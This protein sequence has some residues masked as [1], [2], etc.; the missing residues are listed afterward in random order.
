M[1]TQTINKLLATM[2][3]L[4]SAP[5]AKAGAL[6]ST[7]MVSIRGVLRAMNIDESQISNET[8][9]QLRTQGTEILN[10]EKSKSDYLNNV[11][12]LKLTCGSGSHG[13]DKDPV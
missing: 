9:E 2:I 5:Y 6:S 11:N 8:I 10:Y 13:G 3:I 1:K 4:A 7:E 12:E